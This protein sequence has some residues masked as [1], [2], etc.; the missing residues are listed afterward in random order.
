M[1]QS[2]EKLLERWRA[3]R[4]DRHRLSRNIVAVLTASGP[5]VFARFGVRKAVLYGSVAEGVAGPESDVDLLV[6]PL[7]N[8]RYWALMHALEDLLGRP[9]DLYTD[10]DDPGRVGK[11]LER[12]EVVF[13]A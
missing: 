11:I 8:D 1:S 3:E 2:H 4:E 5:E 10:R 12:G 9:V 7:P 6:M 13:E